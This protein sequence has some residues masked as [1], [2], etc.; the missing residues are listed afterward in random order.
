[1]K[2][3]KG[4]YLEKLEKRSLKNSQETVISRRS[5]QRSVKLGLAVVTHN[6]LKHFAV[7][8]CS[9]YRMLTKAN[10]ILRSVKVLKNI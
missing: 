6:T 3:D 1:M 9:S 2:N 8:K 5:I 7:E 10:D 4:V